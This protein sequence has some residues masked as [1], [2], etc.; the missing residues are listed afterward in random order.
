[1]I[2]KLPI[3]FIYAKH[4]EARIAKPL[5]HKD[6]VKSDRL[7]MAIIFLL[8]IIGSIIFA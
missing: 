1:M 6:R 8:T 3:P 7:V 5:T 2:I 4:K